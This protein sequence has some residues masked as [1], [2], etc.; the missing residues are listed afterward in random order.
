MKVMDCEGHAYVNRI[1]GVLYKT[2]TTFAGGF[3]FIGCPMVK[4]R[5]V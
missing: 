1:V 2:K 5:M 3:L 4:Q